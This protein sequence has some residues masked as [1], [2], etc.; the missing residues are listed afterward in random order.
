MKSI[1]SNTDLEGAKRRTL[2]GII[3]NILFQTLFVLFN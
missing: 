1:T 2:R 3:N